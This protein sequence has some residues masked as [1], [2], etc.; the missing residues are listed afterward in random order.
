MQKKIIN[1]KLFNSNHFVFYAYIQDIYMVITQNIDISTSFGNNRINVMTNLPTHTWW[2]LGL[3]GM[4]T[5]HNQSFLFNKTKYRINNNISPSMPTYEMPFYIYH[6][7][8]VIQNLPHQ[9]TNV[10]A[11]QRTITWKTRLRR[12]TQ[13]DRRIK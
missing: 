8:F 11:L 5:L 4:G 12:W 6:L 2:H 7:R 13:Q 10:K 3:F 9:I 1:N